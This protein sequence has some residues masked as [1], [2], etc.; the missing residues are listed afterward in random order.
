MDPGPFQTWANGIGQRF[1]YRVEFLPVGPVDPVV[2]SPTQMAVFTEF[3]GL[4]V[5]S[6]M[7]S[8]GI[9]G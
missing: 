9:H 8:G 7:Q 3:I 2:G 6:N 5:A 1:G 4:Q